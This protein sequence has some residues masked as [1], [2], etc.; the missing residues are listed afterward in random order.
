MLL[1]LLELDFLG[2]IKIKRF[3][4]IR[5]VES[6][7]DKNI[8]GAGVLLLNKIKNMNSEKID[9]TVLVPKGSALTKKLR[10]LKIR[11]I[12]INGCK[13]RSFDFKSLLSYISVI[14]RLSPD[15][16]NSHGCMNS[17][18][19]GVLAS[20]AV[21]IYTRHCDF[22]L[23]DLYRNYFIKSIVRA[24]NFLLSDGIIAVSF[25]AKRNLISLGVSTKQI[26]VIIN[27]AQELERVNRN[28]YKKIKTQLNIPIDAAVIGIFSRLEPYKDHFTFLRAAKSLIKSTN[29]YFIIDGGG[30]MDF[31]LRKFSERL[32]ISDRVRFCGFV[33]DVTPYMNITDINVNCSIGTETS[34][35]ALSEGMSLGIPSVVSDYPGNL[36]MVKNKVNGLVYKQKDYIS[37]A[38][39]IKSLL[40]NTELYSCIS[41][42]ARRRFELELNA[43]KMTRE[44][45][46]Y[47]LY[48]LKKKKLSIGNSALDS[49]RKK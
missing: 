43:G 45:E 13:N 32:G 5:V 6:I 7:S 26:K 20:N 1:F 3:F 19:A 25:S 8:G 14:Y 39:A 46:E 22:P 12:E 47:Y 37:L 29:C 38:S 15:I 49:L 44:T 4:M 42:N 35:L 30:S 41:Q 40:D 36:Y 2:I 34:S 11:V 48:L 28:K 33:E 18:I 24:V 9:I 16:I 21:N 27:G 23:K 31:A 17:R 10:E